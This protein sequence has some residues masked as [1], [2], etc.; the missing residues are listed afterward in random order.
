M[1]C[2]PREGRPSHGAERRGKFGVSIVQKI[3]TVPQRTPSLHGDNTSDLLHPGLIRVNRD[4]S[5]VH[6]VTLK[7]DEKQHVVG[8]PRDRRPLKVP[9]LHSPTAATPM[10]GPGD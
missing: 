9:L 6:P 2:H 8:H 1:F 10:T 7:M 3:T 5:N 4:S